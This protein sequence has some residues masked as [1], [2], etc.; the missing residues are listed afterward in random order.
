[1]ALKPLLA[2]LRRQDRAAARRPQV[3]VANSRHVADRIRRYYGRT[4]EVIHPPVDVGR[5][6]SLP[7]E[8]GDFYL[9]LG[10]VVPYKRVDLAVSACARMERQ[11]KVAGGGRALEP[12]RRQAAGHR[13]IELLGHV[14]DEARAE[15]LRRARALLFPGEE[16]FGIVPVE[17]QAAGLPVIAYGVGGAAESVHDGRTGVLFAE[18]SA[19]SLEGAIE[20]F[21]GLALDERELRANAARFTRERFRSRMAAVIA[22]AA[23]LSRPRL[24]EGEAAPT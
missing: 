22:D 15:L 12:I 13:G 9:V 20:R 21:E 16:D 2:W 6:A 17:A 18:Q 23:G 11:L 3:M 10:R 24:R 1:M 14:S 8:A 5:F 19:R 4:A 7:R